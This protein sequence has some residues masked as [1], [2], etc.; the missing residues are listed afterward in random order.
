M[1]NKEL[2]K[3]AY[4]NIFKRATAKLGTALMSNED[5]FIFAETLQ[6]QIDE[7]VERMKKDEGAVVDEPIK[8]EKQ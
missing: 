3:K 5:E 2:R 6:K 1:T 8:A 4:L 7:E